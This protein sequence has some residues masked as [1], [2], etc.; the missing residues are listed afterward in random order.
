VSDPRT[1]EARLRR[2]LIRYADRCPDD[3][4]AVALAREIAASS[5]GSGSAS[6]IADRLLGGPTHQRKWRYRTMINAMKLGLAAALVAAAGWLVAGGSGLR[7]D[8]LQESSPSPSP[9]A[10]PSPDPAPLVGEDWAFFSGTLAFDG[11]PFGSSDIHQENGVEV[12]LGGAGFSG[13][14]MTTDD[15]RMTGERTERANY[16]SD[17]LGGSGGL[18][19]NLVTIDTAEGSW[20]CPLTGIDVGDNG[21]TE[22]GWCQ[23]AGAYADLRAYVV[24]HNGMGGGPGGTVPVFGFITSGDGLPMPELPAS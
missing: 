21:Y 7:L 20:T 3:V 19:T 13:Q 24:F 15:P 5:S 12:D 9:S 6:S 4:D 2:A 18:S 11:Q 17:E 23:G 14:T 8:L 22:S 10:S 1:F 16:L